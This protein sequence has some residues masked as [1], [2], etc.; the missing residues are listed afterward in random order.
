[1][2]QACWTVGGKIDMAARR[3]VTNKLRNVYRSGSKAERGRI[4][5][6]VQ[7]TTGVGRSTARRL[8]TGPALPAPRDQVD[9][10]SLKPRGYSDDA[11]ALSLL[12]APWA[13]GPA[14]RPPPA[15]ATH[16]D[17]ADFDTPSS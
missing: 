10:G 7:Q 16:F 2:G 3:E 15:A 4:L 6:K 8:L 1:M 13:G 9:R 17:K 11:R 14:G 5:T 12:D